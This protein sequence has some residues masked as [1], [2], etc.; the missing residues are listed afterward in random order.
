MK[1]FVNLYLKRMDVGQI[2]EGLHERMTIWRATQEYL[3]CGYTQ[4]SDCVEEC[5]D[6]QEAQAIADYYQSIIDTIEKQLKEQETNEG[7]SQNH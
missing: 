2:I 5:S 6:P 3:E 4:L 1:G 7:E